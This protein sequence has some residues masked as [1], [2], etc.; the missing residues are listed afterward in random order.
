MAV[1]LGTFSYN[2]IQYTYS[3]ARVIPH[4]GL[5][6]AGQMLQASSFD[7]IVNKEMKDNKDYKNSDILK[8][9]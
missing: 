4:G 5:V 9:F 1:R 3:D 6:I 7:S 8:P 2:T